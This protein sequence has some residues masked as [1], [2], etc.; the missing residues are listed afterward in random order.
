MFRQV[1][2]EKFLDTPVCLVQQSGLL[3]REGESLQG[4]SK[5]VIEAALQR[6]DVL[7]LEVP[8][9]ITVCIS[10]QRKK[11]QSPKLVWSDQMEEKGPL[12]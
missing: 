5:L 1:G 10:T 9:E 12:E 4:E 11:R 2:A 8:V 7:I 6:C 3:C